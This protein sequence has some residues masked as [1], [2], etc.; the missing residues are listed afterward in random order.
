MGLYLDTAESHSHEGNRVA[1][2]AVL[3][4]AE[5][6]MSDVSLTKE[7]VMGSGDRDKADEAR[8]SDDD[9]DE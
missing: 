2:V 8:D 6:M 9:D 4:V 5:D 3:A 1:R 7:A